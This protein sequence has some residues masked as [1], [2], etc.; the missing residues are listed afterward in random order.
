MHLHINHLDA[1]LNIYNKEGHNQCF[2]YVFCGGPR[3]IVFILLA[4]PVA[5]VN[6]RSLVVITINHTVVL[7]AVSADPSE[8]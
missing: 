7:C 4:L 3:Q 5:A 1:A 2:S 8:R 6:T